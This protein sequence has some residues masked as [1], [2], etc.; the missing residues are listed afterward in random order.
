MKSPC[1]GEFT[2]FIGIDWADTKHDICLQPANGG[3]R[4]FDRFEHKVDC[5]EQ[6]ACSMHERFGG[7]IAVALELSKGPLVYALQKYAATSR[8]DE[9]SAEHSPSVA[10]TVQAHSRSSLTHLRRWRSD[11]GSVMR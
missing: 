10:R 1:D 11:E 6:W 9:I 3:P 4:E 2:S 8:S 7:P 5:I